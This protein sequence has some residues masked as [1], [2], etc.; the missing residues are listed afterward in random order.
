MPVRVKGPD[1]QSY[2]FPDGTDK[3]AA[4][5]YFKKKGI[6]APAALPTAA[7]KLLGP[8]ASASTALLNTDAVKNAASH[9]A[10]L[11]TGPAHALVDAP[12]DNQESIVD[13]VGGRGALAADRIAVEPT[14]NSLREA[15]KQARAGNISPKNDY[16]AQ[17]NYHPS[18][19]SSAID[20]IPV[21]GPWSRNIENEAHTKGV[22]PALAGMA[23]DIAAPEIA[24]KARAIPSLIKQAGA[25]FIAGDV[26][27]VLPGDVVSARQR[28]IA[29]RNQG[30][31]L[32]T[33]QAT[34]A[35]VPKIAKKVSEH[36]L[37]GGPKF[38]EN[39]NANVEA[40]NDH[41]S[42]M[43]DKITP[44][45]MSRE[46]FGVGVQNALREHQKFLNDQ[47]GDIYKRLDASVGG[48]TP[49][50][51]GIKDQAQ[52]IVDQN[53]AYYKN[54]P[55]M[56]SGAPG[57]AWSIV[58]RL[59]EEP[60]VPDPKTVTSSILDAQGDPITTTTQP[61][62]PKPDS[63][64]SLHKLRSDLMNMYRS[65]DIVGSNAEGWLKQL[66]GKV[67]ESMTGASSGLSPAQEGEFREANDI[68]KKMKET[69]DNPNSKLYHIVRSPDALSAANSLSNVTPAVARQIRQASSDLGMPEIHQ[70]LQ[71]QT[72]ERLL[73]PPGNGTP[74]LKN[75]PSRFG[76]SQKEQLGGVLSPD[77]IE[78]VDELART[79]K[80]VHADTNP[81]GTA[82][83]QIPV[84]DVAGISGGAGTLGAGIVTGNPVAMAAG[85]AA[86]ATPL[87]SRLAAKTLT[88]PEFTEGVMNPKPSPAVAPLSGTAASVPVVGSETQNAQDKDEE[89]QTE[90]PI[91]E[92]QSQ[93]IH[94]EGRPAIDTGY[95]TS[96][97]P[98]HPL[99]VVTAIDHDSGLPIVKRGEAKE[100]P[101]EPPKDDPTEPQASTHPDTHVFSAS[102]FQQANPGA[103]VNEAAAAAQAAGY[104]VA[105]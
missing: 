61:A 37:L 91:T 14:V 42:K 32:D 77:Q 86:I 56:L 34:N 74:D 43:L 57:R 88:D 99:G 44:D 10:G 105:E 54:H 53:R 69:Y 4:V 41:A 19:V 90:I 70:Q 62:G 66:T 7:Q 83:S 21:V 2:S 48:T 20:A 25:K 95:T 17:G 98:T 9:A 101:K 29:A 102:Q 45:K 50:I 26:D 12:R 5:A 63:W 67:D 3:D 33:A 100:S 87:A 49:G 31:N 55:E 1:G 92:T 71:R 104:E 60:K 58:N 81:S 82:K 24:G 13:A 79:S 65:P 27:K 97:V 15:W 94:P 47:A 72:V 11:I 28:F 18:A 23:T 8:N 68:Y 30:V 78:D 80:V 22:V 75:L 36:S 6:S 93:V 103:D 85:T 64:S 35:W 89:S 76:R 73:D 46:D 96:G 84:S 51:D 40:L 16:D 39:T 59:A 52:K 38:E